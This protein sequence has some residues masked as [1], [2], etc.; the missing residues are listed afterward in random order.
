MLRNYVQW[1][2]V[3][4]VF[5]SP[6]YLQLLQESNSR[7]QVYNA[8]EN[9]FINAT[10]DEEKAILKLPRDE[11]Y[12]AVMAASRML[13]HLYFSAYMG[14]TFDV[15]DA[16]LKQCA[17]LK[18]RFVIMESY[19]DW[20]QTADHAAIFRDSIG[21][22]HLQYGAAYFPFVETAF[23]HS[24]N[25]ASI[26]TYHYRFYKDRNN[27]VHIWTSSLANLASSHPDAGDQIYNEIKAAIA[28]K[29]IILS[30]VSAIAGVYASTDRTR[31][32][33]KAPAGVGLKMVRRAVLDI[34]DTEQELF[35]IDT[36]SGKSVNVI[37]NFTG[38]GAVV[39][40]ARTLA[41]NDNEWRYIPVRRLFCMVEESVKKATEAFIFEPND[42]NT[43]TKV[44]GMIENYLLT[45]WRAGILCIHGP[46]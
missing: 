34:S 16:A 38:K 15:Y 46:R 28:D 44:Q 33:W 27:T 26:D 20:D 13:N 11:A 7:W 35:N 9:A 32:I 22:D 4:W 14:D 40:G 37:R 45:L 36:K 21:N 17:E 39:W 23:N 31:G 12:A 6:E 8:A 19:L 43:W 24:Y 10:T 3:N 30:P 5:S 1:S 42:A 18:D 2:D 29:Y 41:G 25:D